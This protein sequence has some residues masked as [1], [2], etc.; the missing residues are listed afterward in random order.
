[1]RRVN[2]G[3]NLTKDFTQDLSQYLITSGH[4]SNKKY[5]LL[6]FGQQETFAHR[7][8]ESGNFFMAA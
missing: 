1:M 8:L 2:G 5:Y 7:T 3:C 6:L 4:P